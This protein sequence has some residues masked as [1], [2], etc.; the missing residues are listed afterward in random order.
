MVDAYACAKAFFEVFKDV[1]HRWLPICLLQH[2][3][4]VAGSLRILKVLLDGWTGPQHE[5]TQRDAVLF[6]K[7][8]LRLA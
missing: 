5:V 7:E 8:G 1:W 3:L 6:V 2:L 4:D